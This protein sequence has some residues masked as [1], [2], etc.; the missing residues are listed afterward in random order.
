MTGNP[1]L[2]IA[3]LCIRQRVVIT[4]SFDNY[5]DLVHY[6]TNFLGKEGIAY[7]MEESEVA[8]TIIKL[9]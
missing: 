4:K 8:T 1:E 9:S 5:D 6:A 2:L 7:K 3:S